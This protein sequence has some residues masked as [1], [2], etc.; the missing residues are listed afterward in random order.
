VLFLE[1]E[2]IWKPKLDDK[3]LIA[4]SPVKNILVLTRLA[5]KVIVGYGTVTLVLQQ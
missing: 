5:L 3:P 1:G 4:V 2:V